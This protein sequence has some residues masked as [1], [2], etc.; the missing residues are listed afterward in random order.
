S[1][2]V[3]RRARLVHALRAGD[4]ARVDP[5]QLSGLDAEAGLLAQL[6]SYGDLRVLPVLQPAARHGPR[7]P[8]A[9]RPAREQDA[10]LLVRDDSVCGDAQIHVL[11]VTPVRRRTRTGW[12]VAQASC[13]SS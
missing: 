5:E 6:A 2:G 8:S 7:D 4:D 9:L 1:Q 12:R 13:R 11:T 10:V 3:Q